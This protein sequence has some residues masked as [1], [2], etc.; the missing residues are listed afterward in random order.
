M[1]VRASNPSEMTLRLTDATTLEWD[2]VVEG[3]FYD[4]VRGD[5]AAGTSIRPSTTAAL[6]VCPPPRFP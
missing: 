2:P 5:L 4:I 6:P 3:L 1:L